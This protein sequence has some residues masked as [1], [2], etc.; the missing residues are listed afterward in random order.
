MKNLEFED[1]KEAEELPTKK[2][3]FKMSSFWLILFAI[4]C[5]LAVIII[6][7]LL[8]P[9]QGNKEY[10][11]YT[12]EKTLGQTESYPGVKFKNEYYCHIRD[13]PTN[14]KVLICWTGRGNIFVEK[15]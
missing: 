3:I 7:I 9:C 14:Q 10:S 1:I 15:L 6:P 11:K 13:L 2:Q 12:V 8:P 4:F 5:V